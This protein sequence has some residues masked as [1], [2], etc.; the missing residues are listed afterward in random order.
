MHP[1]G[2]RRRL[3]FWG[4][5]EAAALVLVDTETG[6]IGIVRTGTLEECVGAFESDVGRAWS[7]AIFQV[8]HRAVPRVFLPTGG[9]FVLGF[10]D[11]GRVTYL[12][13]RLGPRLAVVRAEGS[14]L[15]VVYAGV[16]PLP[17]LDLD[18]MHQEQRL[19]PSRDELRAA[20]AGLAARCKGRGAKRAD[21]LIR[22]LTPLLA[23]GARDLVGQVEQLRTGVHSL[24]TPRGFSD[25]LQV[26]RATSCLVDRPSERTWRIKLGALV[27]GRLNEFLD[28][29]ST[30][31]GR[32]RTSGR[33][34]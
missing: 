5:E 13:A 33:T 8:M 21:V 26:I 18:L 16:G 34:G 25:A 2:A 29:G 19:V 15:G 11:A 23:A 24:L 6:G 22:E 14:R 10:F 27:S 12:L 31:R 3:E 28:E 4:H 20:M 1:H 30:D 9:C 7:A 32:R 17:F